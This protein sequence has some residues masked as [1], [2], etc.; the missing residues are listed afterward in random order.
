MTESR[1]R[2]YEF[3]AFRLD[4][5][6][7]DLLR[8]NVPVKLYPKQ[9]DILVALVERAG[10]LVTKDELMRIVWP[11]SVVEESNL[12]ANISHLRRLLGDA[13]GHRGYIVTVPGRGYQ[14]VAGV[15]EVLAPPRTNAR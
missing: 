6:K 5:L 15:R 10:S 1:G 4:A 7:R 13:A 9:F 2:V 12:T 14:F 11:D 3:G 8:G